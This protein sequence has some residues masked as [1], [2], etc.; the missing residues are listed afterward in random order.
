MRIFDSYKDEQGRN[1]MNVGLLWEYCMDDFDWQ[2]YRKTVL[3]RV[4]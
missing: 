1:K 2:K 3:E 4:I